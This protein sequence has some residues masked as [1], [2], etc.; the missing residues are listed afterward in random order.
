MSTST[1]I[2]C[3]SFLSFSYTI[4]TVSNHKKHEKYHH[5]NIKK[6]SKRVEQ[7]DV[8]P[9]FIISHKQC[10]INIIIKQ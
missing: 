5:S 6:A 3:F 8:I 7:N 9:T 10:I 4:I 2:K 1:P